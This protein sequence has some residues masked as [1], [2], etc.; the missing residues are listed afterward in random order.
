MFNFLNFFKPQYKLSKYSDN[1]FFGAAISSRNLQFLKENK[2]N[3]II[4][5][6]PDTEMPKSTF[7]EIASESKKLNLHS[8]HVPFS[9]GQITEAHIQ[10]AKDIVKENK[11]P[12]FFYCRSGKRAELMI[13][14]IQIQD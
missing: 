3:T 2:I 6:L 12:F 4:S 10:K 13:N 7:S 8:F 5:L 1:F 11:G 14:K 9:P